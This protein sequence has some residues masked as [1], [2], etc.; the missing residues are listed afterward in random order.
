M[1]SST[2][3]VAIEAEQIVGE[4]P[5]EG[6][7]IDGY[8]GLGKTQFVA[9]TTVWN[10]GITYTPAKNLTIGLQVN[11]LFDEGPRFNDES[12]GGNAGYNPQFGDPM[13]RFFRVKVNYKF[14]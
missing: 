14:F 12:S 9:T 11:N 7:V 6:D 2:F 1:G 3:E 8:A 10:A 5:T 4:R 13:G